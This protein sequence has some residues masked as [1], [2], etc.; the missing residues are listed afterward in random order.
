MRERE[1]VIY[2]LGYRAAG[3]YPRYRYY[4]RAEMK[5]YYMS[6]CV[7]VRRGCGLGELGLVLEASVVQWFF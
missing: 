2:A 4:T 6:V 3:D 5:V 1:R 7:T